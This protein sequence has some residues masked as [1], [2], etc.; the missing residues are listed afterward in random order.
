MCSYITRKR[1]SRCRR[2]RLLY[3]PTDHLILYIDGLYECYFNVVKK[4]FKGHINKVLFY[5]I[6]RRLKDTY[7]DG[8]NLLELLKEKKTVK[9]EIYLVSQP[10]RN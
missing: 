1:N 9:L 6:S 3:V 4:N 2:F 8:L 10:L 7:N 5:T